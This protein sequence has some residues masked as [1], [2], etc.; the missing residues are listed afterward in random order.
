MFQGWIFPASQKKRLRFIDAVKSR[1]LDQ[2][3]QEGQ[4]GEKQVY[5][6]SV[7]DKGQKISAQKGY[8]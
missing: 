3:S 5:Y 8:F 1:L 6:D 4:V 7:S 2:L